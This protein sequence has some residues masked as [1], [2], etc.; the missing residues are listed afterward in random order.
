MNR[1]FVILACLTF[2]TPLLAE[3]WASILQ[4]LPA[5]NDDPTLMQQYELAAQPLRQENLQEN[6]QLVQ[7]V[8][9]VQKEVVELAD[10]Y[11]KDP[12]MRFP[13]STLLYVAARNDSVEAFK[14]IVPT[15]IAHLLDS[16]TKTREGAIQVVASLRPKPPIEALQPLIYLTRTEDEKNVPYMVIGV[17]STFCAQSKEAVF[18]LR[19]AAAAGQPDSKRAAAISQIGY[20]CRDSELVNTL[21]EGLK[22][23]QS[24]IMRAAIDATGRFGPAAARLRDELERIAAS[25][26]DASIAASARTALRQLQ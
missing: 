10:L 19:D 8:Q 14:P 17:V 18:A 25:H 5:N 2:C 12:A 16:D 15:M 24:N 9:K 3:D 13:I 20:V 4:K 7:K 21:E 26:P 1:A 6:S 23:D 11:D 22:S